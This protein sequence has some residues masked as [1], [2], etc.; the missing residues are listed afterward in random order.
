MNSMW[1]EL[2]QVEGGSS[3][4]ISKFR[5]QNL[6]VKCD[7]IKRIWPGWTVEEQVEF[8]TAYAVKEE[9]SQE[10]LCILDFLME[11]SDEYTPSI[12]A[13]SLTRHP[14]RAKVVD[15]L[16]SS[17]RAPTGD[18]TNQ[19]FVLGILGDPAANNDIQV[20]A[21]RLVS[22]KENDFWRSQEYVYACWALTKLGIIP[23]DTL[24]DLAGSLNSSL[25]NPAKTLLQGNTPEWWLPAATSRDPEQ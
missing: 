4:R 23:P 1:F 15:F 6:I 24:E 18:K 14:N 13:G 11:N 16:S 12:I 2:R 7:E 19:L 25:A 10:D 9:L 20:L 22:E 8:L 5:S 17:L 3:I 21:H